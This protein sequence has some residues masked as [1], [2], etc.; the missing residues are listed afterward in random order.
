MRVTWRKEKESSNIRKHGL[1]F[2]LAER[3][4]ANPLGATLWDGVVNGEERWRTIGSAA[5]GGWFKIV[6]IVHTYPEPGR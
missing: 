2:S 5:N 1:D 4:L 6:V 3:V